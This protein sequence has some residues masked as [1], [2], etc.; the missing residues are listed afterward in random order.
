MKKAFL[1]LLVLAASVLAGP[2]PHLAIR[3][4]RIIPVSG[5]VIE[6]GTV[7]VRNGLIE[8][9]GTNVTVPAGVWVIEGDALTVYPGLI[10][11]LSSA[12]LPQPSSGNRG[13]A[14]G[15]ATPPQTARAWGPEDRPGTTSW[16]KA[17]DLFKPT[18]A[19]VA[20]ARNMGFTTAVVFPTSGIAAGQGSA[21][22]LGG[23]HAG[24]MVLEPSVGQY[25][26]MQPTGPAAGYPSSLMGVIAYLKQLYLDAGQYAKAKQ[27]YAENPKGL[28]RPTY[29]RALEGI[30]ASPR[31]LLPADR[32]IHITRMIALSKNL[33]QPLVIYGGAEGYNAV[34][35]LQASNTPVLVNLKW[36]EAPADRD[37]NTEDSLT[38]L[39]LRAKAP[40]T[41]ATLAKGSVKFA[42]YTGGIEKA[43]DLQSSV[44]RALDAGLSREDLIRALTL[45]P[46]EIFGLSDRL[47]SIEPGKI[48]NLVVTKGELFGKDSKIE[49]VFI[50]GVKYEPKPESPRRGPGAS[51]SATEE[52]DRQ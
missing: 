29:D 41:P 19:S 5:P 15:P 47:G 38:T 49:H 27:L 46:A 31:V 2:P 42:L 13:S 28:A 20:A 10:D 18:E 23:E 11:A 30:L 51:N 44:Q 24:A 39:T 4:A 34:S 52:G 3:N 7:L 12:G 9:V 40:T 6:K 32:S 45:S 17:I 33:G 22:Q 25:L 16:Q 35:A 50:D 26:T 43:A 8:A 37:P 36:P 14:S 21:V 1:A 48:A